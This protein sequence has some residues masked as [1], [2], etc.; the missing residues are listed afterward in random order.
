[1]RSVRKGPRKEAGRREKERSA[2]EGKGE[3]GRGYGRDPTE[4]NR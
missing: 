3:K 4:G 2:L 1:M